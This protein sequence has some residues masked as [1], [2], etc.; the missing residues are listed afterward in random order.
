MEYI[1]S[2]MTTEPKFKHYSEFT[3]KHGVT[4]QRGDVVSIST[5]PDWRWCISTFSSDGN[6]MAYIRTKPCYQLGGYSCFG[7]DVHVDDM[8]FI[9]HGEVW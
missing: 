3:N 6:G 7:E 2:P 5:H 1:E 4:F 8:T 9:E